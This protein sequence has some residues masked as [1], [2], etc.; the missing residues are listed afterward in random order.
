M[1]WTMAEA[2]E[3]PHNRHRSTFVEVDGVT[4]PAPAP[5]FSRSELGLPT[6]AASPGQHSREVLAG[7]GFDTSEIDKLV[8]AGAVQGQ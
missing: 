1:L 5:R 8:E 4:Q 7:W 3:H 6:V 2:A